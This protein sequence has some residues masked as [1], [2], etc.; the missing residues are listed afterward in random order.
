MDSN[1]YRQ[2]TNF[3]DLLT[4]QQ[5]VFSLV[6]D[7]VPEDT[8]AERKERRMWTPVEDMVLISSWL[9]TS[10]DPVVGNEQLSGTFWKRI[11]AY[12]AATASR[13]KTSGQ[14][15][16]DVLKLAHEIFFNNP[17]KKIILEHAWKELRNDQKWCELSY[18]GTAKRRKYDEGSQSETSH[19][20]ETGTEERPSGV[21]AAKGEKKKNVEGKETLS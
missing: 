2:S 9:N 20:N 5:S 14:N 11:A 19:A 7:I 10:K 16:N 6:E 21:K 17:Q 12:F 13:E 15:E 1:P 18:Q 4:S 8:P 3:V